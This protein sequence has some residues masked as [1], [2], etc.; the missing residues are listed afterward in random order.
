MKKKTNFEKTSGCQNLAG[1]ANVNVD[2]HVTT[3]TTSLLKMFKMFPD[4]VK[5]LLLSGHPQELAR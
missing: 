2:V 5:P 1:M 3:T 4:T